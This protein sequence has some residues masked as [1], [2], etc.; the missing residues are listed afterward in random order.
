MSKTTLFRRFFPALTFILLFLTT[1]SPGYAGMFYVAPGG[2]NGNPGTLALPWA[3]PGYGSRQLQPG[4]TLI[5]RN[6]RYVLS[7]YDDDIITPPSGTAGAWITI[8]GEDGPRPV[9]AGRDNLFAAMD[10]SGKSYVRVE[11]LEIAHDN[12]VVAPQLYFR[13]G[14]QIASQPAANLILKDLYIHH[15]DSAG[16][17]IQDVDYL[18]VLNCRLE[19]CGD[20]AI[21]GPAPAFNGVRHLLVQGC[22]LS[23][24]GHYYQGTPGPNP[25]YDR[26]DGLGLEPSAGPLEIVD[27][28]AAHNYGDGLDSKLANT[29]IHNCIV[30]NNTCDGI[31]LWD[32]NSKVEN[33]LIYGMADGVAGSY[34]WA[35]LVIG[36]GQANAHFE[37]INVTL[38]DN[39][40][41]EAYP[42]YVQYSNPVAISLLLRNSIIANG[43]GVAYIGLSVNFTSDHNLFFRPGAAEQV[44]A[45]GRTY[46]AAELESGQLGPGNL[47]RDPKFV[48]PAWGTDGDYHLQGGSPAIDA[49][50]AT[51]APAIDLSYR[52]RPLGRGVDMGA[53]EFVPQTPSVL[54][55]MLD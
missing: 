7:V 38:H 15:I 19:Y 5:I 43:H 39:P 34:P 4:D 9:L 30:A 36:T 26:P 47:S 27:T 54:L 28:T 55:L 12:T 13:T 2:N 37:I 41:R 49:G 6:G 53:Y 1:L 16:L 3:T 42:M 45:N 10:L 18:Q 11:H 29:Y 33:C 40:T 51:G 8:K 25:N 31:K 21:M 14:V 46:T 24:S 44:E 22:S 52:P 20:G 35:G 32:N 23:Y 17:N 50:T 48:R